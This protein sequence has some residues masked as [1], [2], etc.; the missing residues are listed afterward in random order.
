MSN[1]SMVQEWNERYP[2]GTPVQLT[3]DDDVIEETKTRSPAWL[4]GSG[5][6]VVMVEGRT[7]GYS[8]ERIKPKNKRV[9][10]VGVAVMTKAMWEAKGTEL[11][12]PDK[13]KWRFVCPSCGHIQAVEDFRAFKDDGATP[14]LAYSCCIGRYD[15]HMHVEMGTRPGPCN[16]TG[17]GLFN[18]CPV[19]VIDEGKEV[20]SFA[21]AEGG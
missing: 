11:F 10:I 12:G 8:L 1:E 6:P 19:M 16:Y 3:N 9:F 15:G 20:R 7:G 18:I 2:P 4:L 21:F 17:Y 5:H 14:D 13:M